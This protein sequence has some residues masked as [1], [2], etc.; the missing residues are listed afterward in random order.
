LTFACPKGIDIEKKFRALN[1][2]RMSLGELCPW[3]E[4]ETY[5]Y[6]KESYMVKNILKLLRGSEFDKPIKELLL[7]IK[8]DRKLQRAAR[9]EE[10]ADE[11]DIDLEDCDY[12]NFK[13]G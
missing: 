10:G 4:R 12:L 5:L 6:A 9:N 7:E 2:E 13:E 1:V 11:E 3:G 8:F